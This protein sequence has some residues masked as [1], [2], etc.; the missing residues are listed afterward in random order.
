MRNFFLQCIIVLLF[1]FFGCKDASPVV[2]PDSKAQNGKSG[3]A[4]NLDLTKIKLTGKYESPCQIGPWSEKNQSGNSLKKPSKY[5]CGDLY[6]LYGSRIDH[7]ESIPGKNLWIDLSN[8]DANTMIR[9]KQYF[10]FSGAVIGADPNLVQSVKNAGYAAD[11]I[12][13]SISY[14]YYWSQIPSVVNQTQVKKFFGDEVEHRWRADGIIG[15]A[16]V[17]LNNGATVY[18]YDWDVKIPIYGWE[19]YY[20]DLIADYNVGRFPGGIGC[21]KYYN[22][23]PLEPDGD[24]RRHWDYLNSA[25]GQKF[26]FAWMN[27]NDISHFS[28]LFGHANNIGLGWLL[29]WGTYTNQGL[30]YNTCDIASSCGWLTRIYRPTYWV[31]QCINPNGTYNG[32][33]QEPTSWICIGYID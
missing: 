10:G 13:A 22:A 20:D 23:G 2:A 30:L 28:D 12:V 6:Y 32:P 7:Y 27:I 15:A 18:G 26:K 25:P 19:G 17:C 11:N 4:N 1:A 31:Y 3:T 9:T 14:D 33:L 29:L 24:V 21:D 8:L 5:N 16:Q